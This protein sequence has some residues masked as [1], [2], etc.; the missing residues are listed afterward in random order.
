[1]VGDVSAPG[2]GRPDD[3]P[4][5]LRIRRATTDDAAALATLGARTFLAAYS[6][7]IA[8][9]DLEAYVRDAFSAVRMR[10][11]LGEPGASFLVAEG[12]EHVRPLGYAHLRVAHSACVPAAAPA[13]L[14]RLYVDPARTG[15]GVGAQLLRAVL[16]EARSS[17]HD[18][19]WLGVW[20]RNLA[21]QRFYLRWG[22]THRGEDSFHLGDEIQA[23]RIMA[24]V[25]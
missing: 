12:A 10:H 15:S 8:A 1:V 3:E 20:E 2:A 24:R 14:V 23:D 21:A 18:V 11:D 5:E 13:E 9:P 6:P 19:L 7:A 4:D 16:A 25:L 22:F 17:G